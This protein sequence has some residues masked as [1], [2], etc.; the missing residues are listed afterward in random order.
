VAEVG[1]CAM[2]VPTTSLTDHVADMSATWLIHIVHVSRRGPMATWTTWPR[3]EM[4]VSDNVVEVDAYILNETHM[5]YDK[6]L[7]LTVK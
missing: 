3:C 2:W 7:F 1:H 4:Y 6:P 5:A